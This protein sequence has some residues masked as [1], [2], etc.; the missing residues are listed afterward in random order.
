MKTIEG[1]IIN[2]QIIPD[3]PVTWPEGCRVRIEAATEA[4]GVTEKPAPNQQLLKILADVAVIHE[5]MN[6]KEDP[7]TLK[8]LR[9]ARSGAMYGCSEGD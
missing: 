6:P 7:D 5:G 3:E 9:E 8:Y 4:G 1:T 2:G